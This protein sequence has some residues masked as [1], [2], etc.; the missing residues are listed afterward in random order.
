MT[1]RIRHQIHTH[2]GLEVAF[3]LIRQRKYLD[4]YD[5]FQKVITTDKTVFTD[6]MTAL[7]RE[8]AKNI[9]NIKLRL[10]ISEL[11]LYRRK[12][13]CA[14][15]ELEEMIQIDPSYTQSYFLLSKYYKRFTQKEQ[16]QTYFEDAF[17]KGIHDSSIIETLSNLYMTQKNSQKGIPFYESLSQSNP[18]I[19][20][21]K[22][23]AHFYSLENNFDK[24]A[25]TF[26]TILDISPSDIPNLMQDCETLLKRCP[27]NHKLHQLLVTLYTRACLPEKAVTLLQDMALFNLIDLGDLVAYYKNLLSL[28]PEHSLIM[29]AY[30][31]CLIKNDQITE[32]VD[33]LRSLFEVHK[34]HD[35][36]MI[37]Q[38]QDILMKFPDNQPGLLLLLDIQMAKKQYQKALDTI[39]KV[40]DNRPETL[41]KRE[42][43][44]THIRLADTELAIPCH[45]ALSQLLAQKGALTEA[46]SELEKCLNSSEDL[47]ARLLGI[48]LCF[49]HDNVFEA[50]ERLKETFERYPYDL[51]VHN[52]AKKIFEKTLEKIK[53]KNK[54]AATEETAEPNT[55]AI[56]EEG[57]VHLCEESLEAAL[58]TF[59]TIEESDPNFSQAQLLIGRC[60]MELS[61]YDLAI[62]RLEPYLGHLKPN[63]SD[64]KNKIRY[65]LSINHACS[66]HYD[67]ALA[68]LNEIL[69]FDI[70]FPHI[71][72]QIEALKKRG[73]P[74]T[75]GLMVSACVMPSCKPV[76]MAAT[77]SHPTL[78]LNKDAP[79]FA[80][81]HHEKGI[82]S[83]FKHD[84]NS[85]QQSFELAIE[86]DPTYCES[87][88][89]LAVIHC[90]QGN[91]KI[92]WEHIKSVEEDHPKLNLVHLTKGLYFFHQSQFSE[93]LKQYKKALDYL[94]DDA[95]ALL[96]VGDCYYHQED[97]P[98]AFRYWEN[99]LKKGPYFYLIHRR[100]C[101][102]SPAP[103]QSYDWTEDL[104]LSFNPIT[105]SKP[106]QLQL[107][108]P[109]TGPLF[110][111]T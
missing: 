8:L 66:G 1:T 6:I 42:K 88:L 28:F 73:R 38:L 99:S 89:N 107:S 104:T 92:A 83:L 72:D 85:A 64:L 12:F 91:Y 98:M 75:K 109:S 33:L 81:T 108:L 79:S 95:L 17:E 2:P 82:E 40:D 90:I 15:E 57:L 78:N 25:E 11:Y 93:A 3:S 34:R 69:A 4:A 45:L 13:D 60:F 47:A 50:K 68:Y 23:L 101:Y 63:Q 26:E 97:L 27:D 36:A 86:L 54:K 18:K 106:T 62:H 31:E 105:Q 32:A 30:A 41:Q 16:I 52:L 71:K 70:G 21:I 61:R 74:I 76:L 46:L 94:P 77:P 22:A 111:G 14:F 102:L 43:H 80:T 51:A 19:Q 44:I 7:Y 53:T 24:A 39:Q 84:L 67:E 20:H 87:R 96:C 29:M 58:A 10:I 55:I 59:Q 103:T 48:E 9:Q 56:L 37:H 5:R 65:L 35:L 110:D 49:K 100:W